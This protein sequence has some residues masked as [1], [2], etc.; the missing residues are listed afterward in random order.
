MGERTLATRP[1]SPS[2]PLEPATVY[3]TLG[4]VED[5]VITCERCPRLREWCLQVARERRRMYQDQEYW[6]RPV[7]GFGDA[8]AL[9]L[10]VGLAPAAHGG[11]R[12]GRVFT[13]DSSGNWLYATLHE[14]DFANQPASTGRGDSMRL[15]DVY[16][17]AAARCAPPANR[18]TPQEIANCREYLVAE[19]GLLRRMRFVLTLG[20]VAH[21]AWLRAAGHWARMTPAQ[22]P[23]FAH[24]ATAV[25]PDGVRLACSYHPS[26]Q[27]TN[28]G[29]L[30]RAMWN[31]VFRLARSWVDEAKREA[32]GGRRG[33]PPSTPQK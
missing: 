9:L 26:Q 30:T 12:T 7:P 15:T 27:N 3:G 17:T 29:R 32:P 18:P 25:M 20:H 5:A 8:D 23:K 19:I 31:D 22:R 4:E 10:I 6:G 28:T 2:A 16:V 13:G 14:F 21:E 33:R 1:S 24:G 11:N